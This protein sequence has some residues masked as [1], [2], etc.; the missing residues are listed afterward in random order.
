MGAYGRGVDRAAV[1]VITAGRAASG[2]ANVSA[3]TARATLRVSRALHMVSRGALG[4]LFPP[5]RSTARAS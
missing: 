4:S 1:V 3:R 2:A 5:S